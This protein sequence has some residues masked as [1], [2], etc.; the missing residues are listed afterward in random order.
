MC[1]ALG[2]SRASYYY[3]PKVKPDE[4]DLEAE[5]IQVFNDNRKAYG[6][7]KIKASLKK[8]ISRRKIGQIMNKYHLVSV[9]TKKKFK[10]HKTKVNESPIKNELQRKFKHRQ[11][12]EAVVTDL[13]YVN[14][15][16]QWHYVCLILD[17]FNRELIG[18]AVGAS[19]TAELVKQAIATIPYDCSQIQIFHTDRG[20]EFDNQ[21]IDKFLDAFE[22]TRSLSEKGTP[23][24]NA[25]AESTYKAFKAE[26]VYQEDFQTLEELEVKTFD[27]VNWWNNIRIHGTLNYKTPA[28]LR[29]EITK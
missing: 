3:E 5:I 9:Y 28:Q 4:S 8:K 27:F 11:P 1:K 25:V 10:A 26:F 7:R 23:Y 18:Y 13:T 2:I 19:K 24:D 6:T 12:L 17:L 16:G 21:L 20:S 29:A 15:A 22:I 14:V